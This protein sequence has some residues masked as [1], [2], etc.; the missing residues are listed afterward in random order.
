MK[1]FKKI[2]LALVAAMTVSS[3]VATPASAAPMTVSVETYGTAWGAPATAGTATTTAIARPVPAD[4]SV[5]AGDV[6]KF[7]AT[8][9]TG[10]SVSVVATNAFIIDAVAT[11]TAP[12]TASSGASSW[13]L[14][15][16]TGTTATFYVYTK[17]TA[18]GTVAITNGGTTT[19]YYVQG[20]V[21]KINSLTLTGVDSAAAGT[22]VTLTATALDVFGNKVSGKGLT[23][24]ANGATLV[25]TTGS[26]GTTLTDFGTVDFKFTAPAT[27]P[28][29]VV[30]YVTTSTDVEAETTGFNKPS[31]SVVKIVAVRD[32]AAELKVA[33]DALAAEKA[34]HEATKVADAKA[35]ADA[36]AAADLA[37]AKAAAD[38]ANSKAE[39]LTAKVA[40]DKAIADLTAQVTALTK[41]VADLKKAYNAMAK[42]YKFK[43][44]K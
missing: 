35:L 6:V 13:S 20:T 2:A 19:T 42:K 22:A 15:V 11:T 32:L 25:A 12:K 26:T 38:L 33:Q 21:G 28:V 3:L 18:I 41:S 4:N 27:G 43:T 36:K 30:A 8:V 10:T 5:D 17:T 37:A 29:T 16:G 44:I 9:D 7:V 23:A 39:A 14:N 1:S 40:S 24:I 31:S 34:A